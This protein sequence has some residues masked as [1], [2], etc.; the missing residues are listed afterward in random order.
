MG[1]VL[2]ATD[3]GFVTP[4]PN[5]TRFLN[6]GECPTAGKKMQIPFS[7]TRMLLQDIS[8]VVGLED[9]HWAFVK[10]TGGAIV[11]EYQNGVV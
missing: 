1:V 5:G 8:Y 9:G 4:G 6:L 2:R 10:H 7:L 11:R 3:N